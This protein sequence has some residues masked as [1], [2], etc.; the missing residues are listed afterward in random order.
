MWI[1]VKEKG[2]E[3]RLIRSRTSLCLDNV[4]L[5]ESVENPTGFNRNHGQLVAIQVPVGI[6]VIELCMAI[7]V[8]SLISNFS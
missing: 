1:K 5:G 8:I 7:A 4:H 6:N 3:E 2:E